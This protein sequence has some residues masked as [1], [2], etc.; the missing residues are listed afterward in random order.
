MPNTK[1]QMLLPRPEPAG[2][3]ALCRRRGGRSSCAKSI[4]NGI[5]VIRIFDALN[6]TRN[7]ETAIKATKK[8]G[9]IVRGG[10]QLHRQPRA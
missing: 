6:D 3:Q 4:E 8:Y 7:L 10:H 1:L 2:L 9:G 5:D